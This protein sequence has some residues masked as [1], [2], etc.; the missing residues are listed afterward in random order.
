MG[1]VV[2]FRDTNDRYTD[3]SDN[4][5]VMYVG[6]TRLQLSQN[7]EQ[8]DRFPM[9]ILIIIIIFINCNWVITRWQ[10][11]CRVILSLEAPNYCL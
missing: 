6:C 4:A 10:W 11:L 3:S 2:Q 8:S 9:I 1:M 7:T 5:S